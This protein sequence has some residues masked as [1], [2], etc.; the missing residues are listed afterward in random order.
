MSTPN[1]YG[2]MEIQETPYWFSLMQCSNVC[3]L[4][5]KTQLY[6]NFFCSSSYAFY[7]YVHIYAQFGSSLYSS[8]TERITM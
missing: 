5:K 7:T 2:D 4:K 8:P 6:F 3:S 1:R